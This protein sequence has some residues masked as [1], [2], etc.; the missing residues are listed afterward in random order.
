MKSSMKLEKHA[1]EDAMRKCVLR[2]EEGIKL[3]E[4]GNGKQCGKGQERHQRNVIIIYYL[5]L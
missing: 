4:R 1:I 2:K 3:K 5:H